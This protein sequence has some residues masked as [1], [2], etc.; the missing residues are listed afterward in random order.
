MNLYDLLHILQMCDNDIISNIIRVRGR[1]RERGIISID[2]LMCNFEPCLGR[3][4]KK[5]VIG[6]FLPEGMCEDNEWG[7]R[8][9]ER[10]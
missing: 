4:F 6:P 8:C 2:F 1:G 9:M 3:K 5:E 10:R 7:R